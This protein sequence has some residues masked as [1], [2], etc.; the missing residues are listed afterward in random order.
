MPLDDKV[1]SV[2]HSIYGAALAPDLWPSVLGDLAQLTRA[3]MTSLIDHQP[4]G[5]DQ[6]WASFNLDPSYTALYEQHFYKLNLYSHKIRPLLREGLVAPHELYSSDDE[7]LRSEFFNDFN[8]R[9]G[10]LRNVAS[11]IAVEADT[12]KLLSVNGGPDEP[13]FSAADVQLIGFFVPHVRRALQIQ[14]R[15]VDL[16]AQRVTVPRPNECA[17]SLGLTKATFVTLLVSGLS[18]KDIC[19]RLQIQM[20]TARTHLRHLYEKTNT[21][22]QAELVSYVLRE[23]DRTGRRPRR[24]FGVRS[25]DTRLDR[26]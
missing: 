2:V 14:Q 9:I 15:I 13:R 21:T 20:T 4:G 25:S 18:V 17:A 5:R 24:A 6:V 1:A 23:C 7:H 19:S 11:V 10:I 8:R 3:R 26:S 22:R 12:F 16:E